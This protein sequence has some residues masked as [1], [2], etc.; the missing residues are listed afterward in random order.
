MS[1][2]SLKYLA[3]LLLSWLPYDCLAACL[4]PNLPKLTS[5]WD[6]I[7]SI[8]STPKH[9]KLLGCQGV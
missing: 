7:T 1:C 3:V 5:T 2:W 8:T 4:T 9:V 6:N